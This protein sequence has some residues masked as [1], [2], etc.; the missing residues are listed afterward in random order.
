MIDRVLRPPAVLAYHGVGPPDGD[1]ARLLITLDRLESQIR[2]LERRGYR[3]LTAEGILDGGAP[4]NGTAVLTF[5]DGFRSWL[6]DV[7]PLLVRFGVRGTFY[8]SSGLFGKQHWRVP[9]DAGRLLDED[10]ARASLR[11]GW[12]LDRTRC[13]IPTCDSWMAGSSPSSSGSRKPLSSG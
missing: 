13:R 4:G 11:T 10:E 3:F 5:D 8:V 7:A 6:T 12:S 1:D 2:Y 9:G